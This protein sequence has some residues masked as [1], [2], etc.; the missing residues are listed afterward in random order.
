MRTLDTLRPG[1]SA[2]VRAIHASPEAEMRLND[3]GLTPGTKVTV[4][5]SAPFGD[6]MVVTLLGYRLALR[7]RDARLVEVDR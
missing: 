3:M 5:R 4:L 6:P 2:A 1:E 7:R